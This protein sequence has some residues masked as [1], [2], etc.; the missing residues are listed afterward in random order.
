MAPAL[1]SSR[2]NFNSALKEGGRDTTA[3]SRGNRVR[4]ALVVSEVALALMLL[5]GA[6]LLIKSFVNLQRVDPG[7]NPRSVLRADVILPRTRYPERN[8]SA[9]FYKQLLDRVAALPGVQS[10]GAVSTMPLGGGGTDSDFG[11]EGRPP[12]EAGKPQVAWFSSVTPDYFRA[13]GIRLLRG[14]EF[15]EPMT[16]PAKGV[17]I[18]RPWRNAIFQTKTRWQAA[19]FGGGMTCARLSESSR[20]KVLWVDQGCS[21]NDVLR[22]RAKC[23]KRDEPVGANRGCAYDACHGNSR[24]GLGVGP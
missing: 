14:R 23:G 17:V 11:I 15:L 3:T 1:L 7:F 22:S 9:A 4:S 8:Q 18:S 20:N 13:M 21:S 10:A 16:P 5:V 6:G 19:V 12:A 24:A 2:T